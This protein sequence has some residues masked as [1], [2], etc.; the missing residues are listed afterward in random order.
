MASRA[1]VIV[2][3]ACNAVE[4]LERTLRDI[5]SGC[6]DEVILVDSASQDETVELARS[7]GLTVCRHPQNRGYGANQK[8]CYTEAL[9]HGADV[10]VMLHPDYQYAPKLIPYLVNFIV[11]GCF[12]VM[13][14]SPIR[15]RREALAGGMPAFKYFVNRFLTFI[16]NLV[17]GYNLSQRHRGMRACSRQDLEGIDFMSN[18]DD[19]VLDTPVLFQHMERQWPVGEISVPVRYEPDSSSIDFRRSVRYGLATLGVAARYLLRRLL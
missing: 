19:F 15:T 16:E 8:T 17:R 10:V 1:R 3:P 11:D 18:S 5:P 9:E 12:D 13:L 4:T 2:L 7:L 6:A 14:G